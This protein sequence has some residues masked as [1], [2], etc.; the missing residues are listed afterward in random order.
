MKIAMVRVDERLIHGQITMSWT[1]TVGANL[2][3]CVNDDVANNSFQKNLM[4][5]AAPPGAKVEIESV[6]AAAEKLNTQ[7]WSNASILFLVRNP[8]DLLRLVRKGLSIDR[9]NVGGVRSPEATIKLTK[10]VSA[11]PA[12]MEA[13]KELDGMGIR[14]EV[15]F[16]PNQGST[17]LNDV[18]KKHG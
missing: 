18:L 5:M 7:A 9:V 3:L 14:I 16:L 12:E 6:D 10:E 2:I 15:Q 8:I 4:K 13:W 17:L 11:T 1:R